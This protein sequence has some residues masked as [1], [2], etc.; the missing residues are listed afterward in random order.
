MKTS[1]ARGLNARPTRTLSS[2]C[3]NLFRVDIRSHA[4]SLL[5]RASRCAAAR[6]D[7]SSRRKCSTA[8]KRPAR[9]TIST[10]NG[11]G[12]HSATLPT[13][14]LDAGQTTGRKP[15]EESSMAATESAM[16]ASWTRKVR[17]IL[18]SCEGRSGNRPEVEAY[19]YCI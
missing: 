18:E 19:R 12:R 6:A 17:S 14:T 4:I 16:T 9:S 15:G 3:M 7:L 10:A 11:P 5:R 1:D 8:R 2:V 13:S